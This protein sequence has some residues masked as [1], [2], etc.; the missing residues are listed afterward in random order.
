MLCPSLTVRAVET[1][2]EPLRAPQPPGE[3]RGL[4]SMCAALHAASETDPV[5]KEVAWRTFALIRAHREQGAEV[6][7]LK[8]RAAEAANLEAELLSSE[9][10]RN[11]L[12]AESTTLRDYLAEIAALLGIRKEPGFPSGDRWAA[13]VERVRELAA[14]G[15][16][17][18]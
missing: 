9:I 2:T 6:E 13:V 18:A 12:A 7:R 4:E 17:V 15:K 1:V 11:D 5:V 14:D 16:G 3:L 8:V 10:E